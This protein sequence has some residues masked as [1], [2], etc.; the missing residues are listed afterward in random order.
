[1]KLRLLVERHAGGA[2]LF[3][4]RHFRRVICAFDDVLSQLAQRRP[5]PDLEVP[6]SVIGIERDRRNAR[7]RLGGQLHGEGRPI[8]AQSFRA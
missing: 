7:D 4:R 6:Q 3:H 2:H 8:I 1:M 5:H